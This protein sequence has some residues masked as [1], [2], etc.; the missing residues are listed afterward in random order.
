MISQHLKELAYDFG[1]IIFCE[2]EIL[3]MKLYIAA[4]VNKLIVIKSVQCDC[5]SPVRKIFLP[6]RW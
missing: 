4:L 6:A 1:Y 5:V 3:E 2:C